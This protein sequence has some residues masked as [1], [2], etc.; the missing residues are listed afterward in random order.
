MFLSLNPKPYVFVGETGLFWLF[1]FFGTYFRGFEGFRLD[2]FA[3]LQA[4]VW[5][6]VKKG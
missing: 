5:F 6:A 3:D 4:F 1:V 2:T